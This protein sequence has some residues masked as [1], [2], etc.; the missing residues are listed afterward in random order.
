MV[1]M[2]PPAAHLWI[3]TTHSRNLTRSPNVRAKRLASSLMP[4]KVWTLERGPPPPPPPSCSCR[5]RVNSCGRKE[6]ERRR[7]TA[8][9]GRPAPSDGTC[10]RQSVSVRALWILSIC[11][12]RHSVSLMTSPK[13]LQYCSKDGKRFEYNVNHVRE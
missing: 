11:L 1:T 6:C 3:R 12:V 7:Q 8:R 5:R 10:C 13:S 2:A 4:A 9:R